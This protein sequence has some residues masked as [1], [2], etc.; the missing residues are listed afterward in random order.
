MKTVRLFASSQS[1]FTHTVIVPVLQDWIAQI[2]ELDSIRRT[3][4]HDGIGAIDS[5][6][7]TFQSCSKTWSSTQA[8][9]HPNGNTRA[10][11]SSGLRNAIHLHRAP[12]KCSN[13]PLAQ[14]MRFQ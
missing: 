5:R 6:H 11:L 14:A 8:R 3:P 10:L 1:P 2:E 9:L 12:K 13:N 4:P 7:L